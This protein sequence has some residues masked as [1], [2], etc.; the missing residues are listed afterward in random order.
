MHAVRPEKIS[1]IALGT[2]SLKKA[3]EYAADLSTDPGVPA[4]AVTRLVVDAA[5]YRTAIELYL[6]GARQQVRYIS[7]DQ[8][9]SANGH[10]LASKYTPH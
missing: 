1:A 10:S 7:D 5:G 2:V 3:E 9:I 6:A 4:G 8:R